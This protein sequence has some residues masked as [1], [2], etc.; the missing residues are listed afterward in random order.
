[1]TRRTM[2]ALAL[3]AAPALAHGPHYTQDEI[4]WMNRQRALDGTK[5][6]DERDVH[7]GTDVEWRTTATGFQVRIEGVWRDVPPGRLLNRNPEDPSP[8]GPDPLLFYTPNRGG[9]APSIWCLYP[10]T[11]S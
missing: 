11:L 9:G 2:L 3:L 6:C 4:A 10:G 5:C 7:I 1:M 8:F